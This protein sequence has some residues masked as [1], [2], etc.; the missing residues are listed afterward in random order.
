MYRDAITGKFAHTSEIVG[1]CDLNPGRL[2]LAGAELAQKG[3]DAPGYL[4]A[5]FDRMV[6][7]T[8]PDG[9]IVTVKDS[10][11]D[12]YIRRAMELGCDVIT[13]K[14]MTTDAD[15]CRKILETKKKTGQ[16]ITV[17]FNYRYSPP[18]TQIKELLM[19]GIIGE[20]L[21][22]D[23]HWVLDTRHG[24]DYYRRWHRNKE[25]SGG[26][27]V[28]KATHHFDL[29][30]WWLSSVPRRVFA[31]G[32]R[33]FYTPHVADNV[34]GLEDRSDRCHTCPEASRCP[35][36][37]D[38][39]GN[40]RLRELYLECEHHDGYYR[41][42]CVFS[43][44]IDIED[45]MNVAVDYES[46]VKMSYSLNSFSPWEGY[47]CSFNGSR[48]RLE[49]KCQETA[50]INADGSVPGAL[51]KEGTWIHIYP[52]WKPAYEVDVWTGEGGHG[53]ADPVMLDYIFDPG[54][55]P[56]DKYMRAADERAGAFSILTGVAGNISI[57]TGRPV[58]IQNLAGTIGMPDYPDMPCE[59]KLPPLET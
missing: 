2:E 36:Q 13:E 48:G 27:L 56:D 58:A 54:A 39:A 19:S 10:H 31:S 1:L 29:V 53:G 45:S 55:Q 26:L 30:N 21:S 4:P 46:G 52:H 5:D 44:T 51:E 57:E 9:I 12:H 22:I 50:Y 32:H 37:L 11:H 42:R 34:Y 23:F 35:F 38:L 49:H 8:R 40:D 17:T 16:K 25:N 20:V 47:I 43:E 7:E 41:D 59:G 18:R 14:P 6:E 15:R 3:A 33:R 24:A 28:H